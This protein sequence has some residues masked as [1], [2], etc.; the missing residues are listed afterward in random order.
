MTLIEA[1]AAPDMDPSHALFLDAAE[2]SL[3]PDMRIVGSVA[4]A[5]IMATPLANRRP[6]GTLRDVDV[7]RMGDREGTPELGSGR[8]VDT[9]LE[10]WFTPDGS[11]LVFPYDSSL[12]VPIRHPEVFEPYEVSRDEGIIRTLHPDVLGK[13]NTMLY[14]KRP[15]DRQ[16]IATY[17]AYLAEQDAH[18]HPELLQPFDEM[19]QALKHRVGY[20]A[21]GIARNT[22]YRAVPESLR[23]RIQISHMIPGLA[24]KSGRR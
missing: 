7:I 6:T 23:K 24:A 3:H 11:H 19:E 20:R 8:E 13:I 10:K 12:Q 1:Q 14:I 9:S 16:S 2:I 18:M 5:A 22:Y 4:R 17:S 21:R 15:K